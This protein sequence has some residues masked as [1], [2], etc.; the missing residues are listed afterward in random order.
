M[1]VKNITLKNVVFSIILSELNF[2]LHIFKRITFGQIISKFVLKF[3]LKFNSKMC[4]FFVCR[5]ITISVIVSY[6]YIS[7][8]PS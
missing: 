4:H 1:G 7:L 5:R 2:N 3:N 8:Q 6:F